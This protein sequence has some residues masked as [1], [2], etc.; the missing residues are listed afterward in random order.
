M[1]VRSEVDGLDGAGGIGIGTFLSAALFFNINNLRVDKPVTLT[2]ANDGDRLFVGDLVSFPF[3]VVFNTTCKDV[4][5]LSSI[6][7]TVM[8]ILV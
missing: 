7:I 1:R 6:P 2:L 3:T 4:A 8:R 5:L